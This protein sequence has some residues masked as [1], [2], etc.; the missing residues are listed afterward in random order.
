MPITKEPQYDSKQTHIQTPISKRKEIE[1]HIYSG[2]ATPL[3]SAQLVN[4]KRSL[5][6]AGVRRVVVAFAELSPPSPCCCD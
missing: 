2:T 5:R 3:E 1:K 6:P 4:T